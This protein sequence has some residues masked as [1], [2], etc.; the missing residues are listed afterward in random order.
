[1]LEL[2]IFEPVLPELDPVQLKQRQFTH[3]HNSGIE[4]G[5]FHSLAV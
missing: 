3:L 2:E 5:F 1:M 4:T